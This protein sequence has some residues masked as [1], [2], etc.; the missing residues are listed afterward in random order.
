MDTLEKMESGA[1]LELGYAEFTID[2]CSSYVVSTEDLT[3]ST[4][5]ENPGDSGNE[6]EQPPVQT[7]DDNTDVGPD[8]QGSSR[9]RCFHSCQCFDVN[10]RIYPVLCRHCWYHAS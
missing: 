7:P 9:Y 3:E 1:K 4:V 8:R 2:H 5:P 6:E 10:D